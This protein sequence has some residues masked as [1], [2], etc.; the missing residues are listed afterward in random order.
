[1]KKIRFFKKTALRAI[2]LAAMIIIVSLSLAFAGAIVTGFR[3]EP[4]FNKVTLKWNTEGENNLKGFDIQRALT[5]QE[6]ELEKNKVASMDAKGSALSKT[7]YTYEDN[8]VFKTS[9]R[10]YYYRLKIIDHDGRFTYSPIITVSP[11]ISSARQTWGSIK[12]M[13]R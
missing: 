2:L 3:G 4:G 8:S 11:T 10:T 13:F 12:A 7:E 6:Q 5:N 9:G 1:M